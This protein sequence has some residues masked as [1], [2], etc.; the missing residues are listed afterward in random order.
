M[1]PKQVLKHVVRP[2]RKSLELYGT[3]DVVNFANPRYVYRIASANGS[4]YVGQTKDLERRMSEH[5]KGAKRYGSEIVS[6]QVLDICDASDVFRVEKS[7]IE[8]YAQFPKNTN[9]ACVN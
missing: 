4:H 6:K 9:V 8:Y 3:R 1:L 2:L 7:W 5:E